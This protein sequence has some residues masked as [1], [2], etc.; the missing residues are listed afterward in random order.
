M[1]R[2]RVPWV[3]PPSCVRVL[4]SAELRARGESGGLEAREEKERAR[5]VSGSVGYEK[6]VRIDAKTGDMRNRYWTVEPARNRPVEP[7]RNPAGFLNFSKM[8]PFGLRNSLTIT[9]R[10]TPNPSLSKTANTRSTPIMPSPF[11]SSSLSSSFTSVPPPASNRRPTVATSF[12]SIVHPRLSF[13]TTVTGLASC[14]RHAA[15]VSPAPV[16]F[17]RVSP[18]VVPCSFLATDLLCSVL[19]F[20]SSK[21]QI[22]V[23]MTIVV[24]GIAKM[25]V[26]EVVETA[27][28]VMQ[29]R[30]QDQFVYVT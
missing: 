20:S 2:W 4:F 17:H 28:I 19:A 30:N 18:S 12:S 7:N 16:L 5:G 15:T 26:G 27:R 22:S 14:L 24:P 21:H 25:F 10:P 11:L 6:A 9:Q 13:K 3:L 23:P 8:L 1:T 29:E